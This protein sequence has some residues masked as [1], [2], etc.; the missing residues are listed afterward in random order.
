MRW[1]ERRL[2]EQNLLHSDPPRQDPQAWCEQAIAGNWDMAD[3]SMFY[4]A[5]RGSQP[6]LAQTFEELILSL[7]PSE[8]GL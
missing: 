6:E 8:G 5:C 4:I 7:I 3:E 1:A 2:F